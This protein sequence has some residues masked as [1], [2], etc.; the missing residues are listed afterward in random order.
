MIDSVSMPSF[1]KHVKD[2][3]EE[4]GELFEERKSLSVKISDGR[5]YFRSHTSA[6]DIQRGIET[7]LK[8]MSRIEQI[9]KRI[10]DLQSES[11]ILLEGKLSNVDVDI[12]VKDHQDETGKT[13][14]RRVLKV[15]GWDD[16]CVD[17]P[18]DELWNVRLVSKIFGANPG[19]IRV[20]KID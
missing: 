19:D 13:I 12:V 8:H 9:D 20:K 7:L 18:I 5:A 11:I 2:M 4:M 1:I 15:S 10:R 14:K 16:E 17:I 3:V 6:S